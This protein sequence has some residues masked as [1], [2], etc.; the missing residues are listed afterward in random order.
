[1]DKIVDSAP[2][3]DD[4]HYISHAALVLG[5][6]TRKR[7]S[8]LMSHARRRLLFIALFV[9][10][11]VLTIPAVLVLKS[12]L[13]KDETTGKWVHIKRYAQEQPD[14]DPN[15][16]VK[17]KDNQFVLKGER[18]FPVLLN[19]VPEFRFVED[20]LFLGPVMA[21]EHVDR[22]ETR[23]LDSA[24]LQL[25]GH[26]QLIKS[27]GFNSLRI[28]L[29]RVAQDD[30]GFYYPA[31]GHKIYLEK[32]GESLLNA[33][34]GLL[35]EAEKVGL[36]VMPLIQTP[37]R[38]NDINAFTEK[39]LRRFN[40]RPFVFAYD[41]LNEPLY[42]DDSGAE[43]KADVAH[44]TRK[45]RVMMDRLAPHQLLTI[46]L[47]EPIE[48]L[49]WDP[50]V[51]HVDFLAFHTYH[52]LRVPNEIYWYAKHSGKPWM[53]GETGLPADGD[54]VSYEEQ[55]QFMVESFDRTVDCGGLGYGWWE[56]QDVPLSYFEGAYTGILNREG[57][58]ACPNGYVMQNTGLKPV[59]MQA[60]Q[61]RLE[62]VP[63]RGC[64]C[65]TNYQNQLGYQNYR[66][67]G[68]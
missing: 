56:F 50:A 58:L 26:F 3:V 62:D 36:Y 67:S 42:D 28:P 65:W 44:I 60:A 38:S 49:V 33:I 53:I 17:L 66:I 40:D 46:G 9:L 22:F 54:S 37:T 5:T 63:E 59:A 34:D 29:D 24:R 41:F 7:F 2:S 19:Y 45:W 64:P 48:V 11:L 14:A 51:M 8:Q 47:S 30:T 52:P 25:A 27:L 32:D 43:S 6:L 39:L 16:F 13:T 10:A 61:L 18:F 35:K 15:E 23:T 21:Y 4:T 55:R 31:S 57:T 1:M 20:Q 68:V 12:L